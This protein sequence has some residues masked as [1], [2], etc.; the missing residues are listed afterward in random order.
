MTYTR[1]A[2]PSALYQRLKEKAKAQG[3]SKRAEQWRYLTKVFDCMDAHPELDNLLS[4]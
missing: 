2:F 4:K 3:Y 1:S